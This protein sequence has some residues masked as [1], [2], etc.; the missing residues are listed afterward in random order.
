MFGRHADGDAGGAV[1]EQVRELGGKD[2][3]FLLVPGVVVAKVD[4][5][6]VEFGKE[7]LGGPGQLGFGVPVR[8]GRSPSTEPKFPPREP[9]APA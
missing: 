4:R 9:G 8:G 3:R 5:V 6:L 1:D 7:G 2:G